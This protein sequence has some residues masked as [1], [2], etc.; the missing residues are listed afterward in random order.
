M[1]ALY[2]LVK[3]QGRSW[4]IA[5]QNPARDVLKGAGTAT[6]MSAGVSADMVH[7]RT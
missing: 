7:L 3:Q 5:R 1:I 2:V 4:I 6:K